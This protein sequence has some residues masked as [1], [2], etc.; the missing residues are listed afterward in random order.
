M[1]H[2]LLNR[3]CILLALKSTCEMA[4][5]L[6]VAA[7]C[8]ALFWTSPSK[9]KNVIFSMA[10]VQPSLKEPSHQIIFASGWNG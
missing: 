6:L 10:T 8:A 4:T 1:I 3:Q 2:N 9:Q 7:T 5:S